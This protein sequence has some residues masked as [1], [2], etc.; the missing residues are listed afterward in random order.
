MVLHH[1]P[2]E[3][4]PIP[5]VQPDPPESN[6]WNTITRADL[7]ALRSRVIELLLRQRLAKHFDLEDATHQGLVA[8]FVNRRTIDPANNG[9]LRYTYVVARNRLLDHR[10]RRQAGELSQDNLTAPDGLPADAGEQKAL[11]LKIFDELDSLDR[12]LLW[13]HVVDKQ[14]VKQVAKEVG[15][16]WHGAAIRIRAALARLRRALHAWDH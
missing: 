10:K 15:L 14:S 13:R 2:P 4:E 12:Y 3:S 5:A 7:L 8:L 9:L 6:W 1:Q 16:H 11:I